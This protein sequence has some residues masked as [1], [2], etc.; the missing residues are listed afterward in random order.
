MKE[1]NA[2]EHTYLGE[3][4]TDLPD[5]VMLNKVITGCGGTT[6]ALKN[7]VPYVILV[8]YRAM[9]INKM[10][11][12]EQNSIELQPVMGGVRDVDIQTFGGNKYMCTYDSIERLFQLMGSVKAKEY[13]ILI[14]E[15]HNLVMSGGYRGKAIHKVMKHY[16]K[17]KSY[18]FMTA[19]PVADKYQ[20]PRLRKINQVKI[21][22]DNLE[23]VKINYHVIEEPDDVKVSNLLSKKLAILALGHLEGEREGNAHIF[24]NSV[25]SIIKTVKMIDKI[26]DKKYCL[27]INIVIADNNK[28]EYRI[29]KELER[30]YIISTVGD[31]NKINFYTS[32]AFEGS[33]IYDKEGVIYIAA[34]GRKGSTKIDIY[35]TL[36]QIVGR[37]RNTK[38]KEVYLIYTPD[39]Y[40]IGV[41][42]KEFEM[43]VKK[44]VIEANKIVQDYNSSD[45]EKFKRMVRSHSVVDS[46]ITIIDGDKIELTPYV[47]Y[48]EM[49][50][51]DARH[52]QYYLR[53]G[54]DTTGY[55]YTKW[56]NDVEYNYVNK[57]FELEI[58]EIAK[59]KLKEKPNFAKLCKAYVKQASIK[60]PLADKMRARSSMNTIAMAVPL[61]KEAYDTLGPK[62]LGTLKYRKKEIELELIK[63]S[64]D[65][66]QDKVL[67]ILKLP[68]GVWMSVDKI[69]KELQ[70]A[71]DKVGVK[72]KAA[73]KH[74]HKFY[75]VSI[76]K[77]SRH[78]DS[79]DDEPKRS[80]G[81]ILLRKKEIKKE[82]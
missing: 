32:T 27:E 10:E 51:F 45:N 26:T 13:K 19:T 68:L 34:D 39:R 36:P 8:P 52:R 77:K 53:K 22:W 67:S 9:I 54:I 82:E 12:A 79:L 63:I 29:D 20:L 72:K 58:D 2:G 46:Y 61:I 81:Y 28:N 15:S 37:I 76:V 42:E 74:V 24:M 33:D 5:N 4:M 35:T 40:N 41:S 80:N 11:W 25:K 47:F 56:A 64:D 73:A 57:D 59:L 38:Y 60:I 6:V 70:K 69:K 7:D 48:A 16:R 21:K 65:T 78:S 66:V 18:V 17:F 14:D 44:E 31:V 49:A 1:I 55:D 50:S 43:R 62:K 30:N 75:T 71:Y 23:P 3:F